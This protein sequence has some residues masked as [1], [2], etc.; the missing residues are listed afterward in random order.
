MYYDQ[1]D[2]GYTVTNT[3]TH[4]SKQEIITYMYKYKVIKNNH[5]HSL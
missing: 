4:R 3:F 2:K 5:I 1:K